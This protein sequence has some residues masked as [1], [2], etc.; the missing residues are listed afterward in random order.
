VTL[1]LAAIRMLFD[2]LVTGQIVPFNPAAAVRGP[3]C[4]S[5]PLVLGSTIREL[6]IIVRST[7]PKAIG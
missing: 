4:R 3:R 6:N 7:I 5:S 1:H 2:Y